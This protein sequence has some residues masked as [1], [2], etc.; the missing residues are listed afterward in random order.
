MAR[1]FGLLLLCT[2]VLGLGPLNSRAAGQ[3]V[4][5]RVLDAETGG[6]IPDA[7]VTLLRA[8]GSRGATVL[9]GPD[10]S[11]YIPSR[12]TGL[13][14]LEVSHLAYRTETT[15]EIRLVSEEEVLVEVRLTAAA[16]E[17]EALTVTGRRR[18][19]RQSAT[20]EGFYARQLTLPPIGSALA[21]TRNDPEMLHA[22]DVKDFLRW[23]PRARITRN[24]PTLGERADRTG[25]SCLILYW[26]G[27]MVPDS[28]EA[29]VLMDWPTQM[30]EGVEYYRDLTEAPS[31]F[32]DVP[33][34][35]L[36]CPF[37]SVLVLWSY[38]GYFG[39][40][41]NL[42]P[43]PFRLNLATG[44][45]H[46]SGGDAPGVGPG[47]EIASHLPTSRR[48]AVGLFAR[49]SSHGLPADVVAHLVPDRPERERWPYA[50]P[51]G[52]RT[53]VLWTG[54]VEPRI[55]LPPL[56]GVWPVVGARLHLAARTFTMPAT[57][58][59]GRRAHIV[60]WGGG[61]GLTLGAEV[62]VGSRYVVQVAA[63]HDRFSFGP[64]SEIERH[65][66]RTSARWAGTSLR[67]GFGYALTRPAR[68]MPSP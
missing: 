57:T 31:A 9:T 48:T 36:E 32:Q 27:R 40:T 53:Q 34:Y 67:V 65:W 12:Q 58:S 54:G 10:G 37:H 4:G 21:L 23:L 11:F 17:L 24:A 30:L 62:G 18:D 5:G 55:T 56:A 20:H 50:L 25:Q 63:N 3:S 46:L 26:N 7:S 8:D 64:Y 68:T 61:M 2:A 35:L 38:T 1:L 47:F 52:G 45:Y 28:G 42:G 43:S 41:P 15:D 13:H 19:L 49:R 29:A 22:F 33:V 60:S 59:D 6:G 14:R 44:I 66:N 16:I 51:A 39:P